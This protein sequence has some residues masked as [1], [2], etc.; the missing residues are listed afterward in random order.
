LA[1]TRIWV[2]RSS[3]TASARGGRRSGGI[4]AATWMA[5]R[6]RIPRLTSYA[7]NQRPPNSTDTVLLNNPTRAFGYPTLV[8]HRGKVR[9]GPLVLV[10]EYG[11]AEPGARAHAADRASRSVADLGPGLLFG[12][13][14]MADVRSKTAGAVSYRRRLI[15]SLDIRP[16]SAT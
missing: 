9:N 11:P 13:V 8:P 2:R 1:P 16:R 15:G 12:P 10:L 14:D 6:S 4:A 5:S 3:S 7:Q